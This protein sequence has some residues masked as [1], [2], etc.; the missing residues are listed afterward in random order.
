VSKKS[1]PIRPPF[2]WAG[3]KRKLIKSYAGLLPD[4]HAVTSYVEPFFGGGALFCDMVSKDPRPRR[5]ILNDSNREL[6]SVYKALRNRPAEFLVHLGPLEA[7]Y[8][9]LQD[10]E[11]RKAFY[12]A[13][14][15][16]YWRMPSGA[17]RTA[18]MLFFLLK[19]SF[20]GIWQVCR[21][22]RGRFA[23]PSGL[24]KEKSVINEAQLRAWSKALRSAEISNVSFEQLT[25]RPGSFVFCDPP[26]R[27]GFAKYGSD[28][29][30]AD[31]IRLIEWCDHLARQGSRV[32]LA[33][34]DLGDDF[35]ARTLPDYCIVSS[36]PVTYTA[37]RKKRTESGFEAKPA[38][39]VLV[40]FRFG[41]TPAPRR[42]SFQHDMQLVIQQT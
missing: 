10:K 32:L 38:L 22:S 37:G 34:R 31:Q 27:G 21:A 15:E 3:G 26:Y 18:A 8:L 24:L 29:S 19:T 13:C 41:E 11:S 9:K 39:E 40:D 25:V 36:I 35:F 28:F 33:N 42:P 12:Y 7:D 2:R 23:T 4:Y 17:V 5:Y 6:M 14:R 1:T 30:D 16:K 20:N